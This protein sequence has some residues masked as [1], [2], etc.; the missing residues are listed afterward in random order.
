M[1]MLQMTSEELAALMDANDA[2]EAEN[3]RLRERADRLRFALIEY[4]TNDGD[5]PY[6]NEA[7]LKRGDLADN[8]DADRP[9]DAGKPT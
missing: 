2:L 3:A 7:L 9:G 1:T 8:L 4:I 5:G 6:D